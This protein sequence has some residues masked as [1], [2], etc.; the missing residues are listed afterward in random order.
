M[1]QFLVSWRNRSC[2]SETPNHIVNCTKRCSKIAWC[3]VQVAV[4]TFLFPRF[5]RSELNAQ[6][7][8]RPEQALRIYSR[9]WRVV[10]L[11]HDRQRLLPRRARGGTLWPPLLRPQS[12]H[13]FIC[14]AFSVLGP[15]HHQYSSYLN[16]R[17]LAVYCIRRLRGPGGPKL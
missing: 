9:G 16:H 15:L 13:R 4:W 1:P 12:F 10:M 7:N 17:P 14:L 3:G 11:V 6:H 2:L 8:L 5:P